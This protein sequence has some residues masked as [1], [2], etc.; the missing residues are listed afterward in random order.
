MRHGSHA[1]PGLR[2]SWIL[3][4]KQGS[5]KPI[6]ERPGPHIFVPNCL[7]IVRRRQEIFSQ[8]LQ[9]DL[10]VNTTTPVAKSCDVRRHG[11]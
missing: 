1:F 9:A 10:V 11:G 4:D 2:Q 7:S 8:G 3:K 6:E 5:L